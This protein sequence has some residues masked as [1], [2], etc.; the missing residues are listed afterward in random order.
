MKYDRLSAASASSRI[1]EFFPKELSPEEAIEAV[2]STRFHLVLLLLLSASFSSFGLLA[3]GLPILY[4]QKEVRLECAHHPDGS[5]STHLCSFEEACGGGPASFRYSHS[6]QVSLQNWVVDFELA[7]RPEAFLSLL[8]TTLFAGFFIGALVFLPLA[9]KVGRKPII[10][11]GLALQVCALAALAF[12]STE[13]V[14]FLFVFCFVVGLRAPMTSQTAY[15]L[16][17]ELAA[18]SW[19]PFF[20]MYI[21]GMD[22]GVSLLLGLA[23]WV[24]QDW[25]PLF[26]AVFVLLL[27]LIPAIACWVPESPRFHLARRNYPAARQIYARIA[28]KS[29]RPMFQDKLQEESLAPHSG[30]TARPKEHLSDLCAGQPCRKRAQLVIL[31]V[32]WFSADVL[33]YGVSY[34]VNDLPGSIYVN[35]C[36]LGAVP[37]VFGLS[38]TALANCLG[39]KGGFFLAWGLIAAGCALFQ[40]LLWG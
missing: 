38:A 13:S 35:S 28:A 33:S 24:L 12:V 19:R 8:A 34:S 26:A 16:L 11:A 18:P 5:G 25:V 4:S 32:A 6:A 37:I 10:V 17:V 15:L 30:W 3:Y 2:S 39:R 31:P 21:N 22:G 9:D 36:V 27:L 40:L 1:S 23:Y 20:S 29:N 14:S 7:C